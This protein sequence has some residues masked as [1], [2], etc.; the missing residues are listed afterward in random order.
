MRYFDAHLHLEA[1]VNA[2][3]IVCTSR[4]EEWTKLSAITAPSIAS[5]GLL[6]DGTDQEDAIGEMGK[7]LKDHPSWQIG[8][9]GLDARFPHMETQVA[10]FRQILQMATT[11][12]RLVSI[13]AVRADGLLLSLLDGSVPSIWHGFTGSVETARC[14]AKCRCVVSL[15]PRT[16]QSN[17]W[18]HL[19][20]LD[21]PFLLET[22]SQDEKETETL[23][24][25]YRACQ[26]RLGLT[27]TQLEER[28]NAGRAICTDHPSDRT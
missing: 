18:N 27:E 1:A 22:D 19:E 10:T 13:H 11:L 8:E 16:V 24:A 23:A 14:A 6:P 20:Q 28:I 17:L 9:V 21:V 26:A 5:V 15:G 2:W 4:R 12:R 3:G 25:M 7:R